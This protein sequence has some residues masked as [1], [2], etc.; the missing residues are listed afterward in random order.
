MVDSRQ[1]CITCRST[2]PQSGQFLIG[3]ASFCHSSIPDKGA[4][5]TKLSQISHFV[6]RFSLS[7]GNMFFPPK[8]KA[9]GVGH[10]S[11]RCSKPGAYGIMTV[12]MT[13]I[14]PFFAKM[15]VLMTRAL[16]IIT[17]PEPLLISTSPPFTV[18]A[19]LRAT[20]LSA[21]TLPATTW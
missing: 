10:N 6:A 4:T 17:P 21:V 20:T 5:L 14:T 9:A 13:W 16:S 1:L 18:F 8:Y 7:T 2:G 3:N 12:S 15:S 11:S 19:F